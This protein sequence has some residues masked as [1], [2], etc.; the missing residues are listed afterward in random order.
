M[1]KKLSEILFIDLS[2]SEQRTRFF[3]NRMFYMLYVVYLELSPKP[4][5]QVGDSQGNQQVIPPV[6]RMFY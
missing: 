4:P 6:N 3:I 2:G 1:N 5:V